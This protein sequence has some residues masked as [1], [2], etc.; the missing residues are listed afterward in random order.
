M[1]KSLEDRLVQI[2]SECKD[3]EKRLSDSALFSAKEEFQKCTKQYSILIPIQRKFNAYKKVKNDIEVVTPLLLDSDQSIQELAKAELEIFENRKR[4]F[5]EELYKAVFPE[6]KNSDKNIIIEIRAG[7]GGTEASIFAADLFRM[8]TKYAESK[9]LKIEV[10][11]SHPSTLGGYK[12]IIFSIIGKTAAGLFKYES[13]VHRVQRVPVTEASGRIHTSTATVVVLPEP[14]EVELVINAED[15]R[16]DTFCSSGPGGQSVNTTYSAIRITHIPTGVVV[17][18][19]E[20]RSQIKNRAKAMRVLRARLVKK[21]QE[22]QQKEMSAERKI[23]IGTGDR[24][25]KVRT[26]NFPQNR[27]TD[28]RAGLSLYNLEVIV[29]GELDELIQGLIAAENKESVSN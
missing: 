20:E 24:S 9:N 28:H 4:E 8:Y 15:L 22:D 19:Q 29:N 27:I 11:D 7:T 3:L 12:D 13:G 6:E 5:E 1:N 14:E 2:E 25:E 17:Q 10:M 16:V 18:C 21:N 23:Q 26:Y